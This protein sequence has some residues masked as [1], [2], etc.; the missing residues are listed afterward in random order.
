M[1]PIELKNNIL[2]NVKSK[3]ILIELL[4]HLNEKKLLEIA[5]Y[6][7]YIKQKMNIN[8]NNYKEYSEKFSSIIIEIKLN[9]NYSNF[10]NYKN[11]EEKFY[12][13]YFHNNK[14][15][16]K[17]NKF[18]KNKKVSNIKIKIDYQIESLNQLFYDCNSIEFIY[19]KQFIRNNII[20]MS[21]MFCRCSSLKELNLN[22]FNTN[23]VTNMY[24]MFSGCSSLKE[25]NLSN[26][27]T[28]NVENM[29]SMFSGCSS[30]KELNLYF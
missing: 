19:F 22:N 21:Y 25:L 4:E 3:Y 9:K 28:N 14:E 15:E 12:H 1:K 6:N 29:G 13:I 17:R 8:I 27:N 26:F 18:D 16:I 5:L 30:L 10:I 7:N 23:N 20:D 11:E 2:K 24:S